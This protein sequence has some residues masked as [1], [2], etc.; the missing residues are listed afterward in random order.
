MSGGSRKPPEALT[1]EVAAALRA[2]A[3]RLQI[4]DTQIA[5]RIGEAQEVIADRGRPA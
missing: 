4:K 1:I 5:E 2:R 3:A